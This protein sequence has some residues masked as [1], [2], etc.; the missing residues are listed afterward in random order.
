M[1]EKISGERE[2]PSI[3]LNLTAVRGIYDIGSLK[4]LRR[5]YE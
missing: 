2:G 3:E 1:G 5:S 4:R